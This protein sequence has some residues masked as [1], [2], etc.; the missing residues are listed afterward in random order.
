M[1]NAPTAF[2][3]VVLSL[4]GMAGSYMGWVDGSRVL[5]GAMVLGG[6][7]GSL[8]VLKLPWDLYFAAR[9]LR[10]E[11]EES[12]RKGIAVDPEDV[13][14][15]TT[16]SRRLLGL[17]LFSHSAAAGLAAGTSYLS[18][19]Q[20]G[21]Y[22][23]AFFLVS[24]TF[25]PMGSFYTHMMARLMALRSRTRHPREDVLELRNRVASLESAL[26]KVQSEED[27]LGTELR[28]L[29]LRSDKGREALGAELRGLERNFTTK[30]EKV[31]HEFELSIEKLTEDKNLLEGIRAFVRMVKS[32]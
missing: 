16:S 15:A 1:L 13:A 6:L 10:A 9:H 24:T 14:F 32:A 17:C 7:F 18:G 30:V 25:R 5:D 26:R 8:L 12:E 31:C 3:I 23:S 29:T 27:K 22:F 19:G 21:Y 20:L 11:Q 2:T 28:Q 4:A